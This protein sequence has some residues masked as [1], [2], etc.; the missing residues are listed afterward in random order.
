[1]NL[2]IHGIDLN[3]SR[4][5]TDSFAKNQHP[6]L[7][8]DFILGN[9]PV[10]ISD[11]WHGSL[12]GDVRC[13]HGDPPPG[14]AN[15]AWL[16]HMLHPFKPTGRAGIV[17]ANGSMSSSQNSEGQI[18]AAMVAAD[19]VEVMIALFGQLFFN[20]QIRACWWFLVKHKVQRA[21]QVLFIDARKLARMI[22]RVQ[23][24]LDDVAL[25]RNARPRI[26]NAWQPSPGWLR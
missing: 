20:T 16:Q 26:A 14:N 15:T 25:A 8:A 5:P 18:R 17:L 24:A 19:V 21:R 9:P 12:A 1:M 3:R 6:D 2:A 23:C 7:R 13:E 22:S 10:S 4:E 11:G